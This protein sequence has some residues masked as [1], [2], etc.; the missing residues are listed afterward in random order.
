MG[1]RTVDARRA[2]QLQA[3]GKEAVCHL[4]A[5]QD[6]VVAIVLQVIFFDELPDCFRD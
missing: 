1:I 3:G 5:G 6:R 4:V 2:G